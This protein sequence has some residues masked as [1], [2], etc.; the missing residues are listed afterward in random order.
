[1]PLGDLVFE[2]SDVFVMYD[3]P[4]WLLGI[5]VIYSDCVFRCFEDFMARCLCDFSD[6]YAW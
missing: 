4:I 6:R 5:S 3:S 1:M 2:Y